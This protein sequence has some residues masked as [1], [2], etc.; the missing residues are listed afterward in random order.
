M[1]NLRRELGR[2]AAGSCVREWINRRISAGISRGVCILV[3]CA[4]SLSACSYAQKEG[5]PLV[6]PKALGIEPMK[7]KGPVSLVLKAS[8]GRQERMA[9]LHRS[10]SKS[11]NEAHVLYQSEERIQF[12]SQSETLRVDPEKGRFTYRLTVLSKDGEGR[13]HDFAMPE[14]GEKLEIVS[15]FQGRILK[16]G[17]Y[18]PNSLFYVPPLSLPE[19]S[20]EVG[21]TWTMQANWLSLDEMVPYRLDMVSILKGFWKC[22]PD[23]CA[24]IEISG[25]VNFEGA[26]RRLMDFKSHWRGRIFFAM[27]AGTVLWS[28]VDSEE[29]FS[30]EKLRRQVNSCLEANLIAPAELKLVRLDQ[31]RCETVE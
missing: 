3:A 13:L 29:V 9:F 8:E 30:A 24:E 25:D 5:E 6:L 20:V 15:D 23:Q 31:P 19:E 18:P 28:R 14:V 27:N 1:D 26:L 4:L 21:D 12:V 17:D 11:W 2:T 7:I 10:V 16:A 22:G